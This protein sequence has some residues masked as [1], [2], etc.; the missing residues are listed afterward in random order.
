MM[1]WESIGL[2]FET[3][4]LRDESSFLIVE[5]TQAADSSEYAIG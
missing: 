5:S 2:F 3:V 1:S 4:V